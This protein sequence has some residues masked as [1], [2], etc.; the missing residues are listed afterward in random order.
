LIPL[1]Y[2]DAESIVNT[3]KPLVS[4]D[5]SMAAYVD[6]NTVILTESASNIRRLLAILEAIDVE[7]YKEELAV[8]KVEF[9]DA[10]VLAEQVSQIYGAEYL[11]RRSTGGL[12]PRGAQPSCHPGRDQHETRIIWL[13]HYR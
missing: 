13:P 9:A 3:L 2:I 7:T 12:R 8:L 4:K 5:A 6:T 1:H 10:T 11:V